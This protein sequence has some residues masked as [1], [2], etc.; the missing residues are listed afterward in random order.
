MT[1]IRTI[2]AT[3]GEADDH[4]PLLEAAIGR[5]LREHATLILYDLDAGSN[6]LM[7]PLPTAWSAEGTEEMVTDRLG[8]EELD[9][10]GRPEIAEQVRQARDRGADAWGWLPAGDDRDTLAAYAARQPAPLLLVA[11]GESE[12]IGEGIRSEVVGPTGSSTSA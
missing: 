9:A 10:A 1:E 5:A 11:A 2:I 12:L 8:P 3:V 6:P 7:N 4:A